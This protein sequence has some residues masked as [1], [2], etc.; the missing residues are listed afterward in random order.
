MGWICIVIIFK[1]LLK[2][3]ILIYVRKPSQVLN[4][5][6]FFFLIISLFPMGMSVELSLLQKIAPGLV[7]IG[8]LLASLLSIDRLFYNDFESGILEQ[9]L[10]SKISVL[11]IIYAKFIVHWFMT[12]LPLVIL[13]PLIAIMYGLNSSITTS[14][15]LSL[16]CGTPIITIIILIL[17]AMIVGAGNRNALISLIFLPLTIPV[18]IFGSGSVLMSMQGLDA[19]PILFLLLG[20][21]MISISLGPFLVKK[22]LYL[23][24]E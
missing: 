12:A 10:L 16:L 17:A 9:Q 1:E 15:A 21:A 4:P 22:A 6:I 13:C 20:F 19:R 24:I 8:L 5:L 18:L 11:Q 3:E 23:S 7:W 2:R 14:L